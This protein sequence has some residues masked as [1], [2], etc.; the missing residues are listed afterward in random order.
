VVPCPREAAAGHDNPKRKSKYI[1][2]SE[3]L[4]RV[5]GFETVCGNVTCHYASSRSSR[6]RP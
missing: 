2:W 4:R 1:K 3:L 6:T 5:F